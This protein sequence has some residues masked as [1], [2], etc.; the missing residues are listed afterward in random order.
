[1]KRE[2]MEIRVVR[3]ARRKRFSLTV[4][5]EG[6]RL[7]APAAATEPEI[8]HFLLLCDSWIRKNRERILALQEEQ[9]AVPK[10]TEAEVSE[11]KKRAK[12]VF[13]ERAAYYAP[14]IGVTYGRITVTT[15]KSKWGSCTG[16]GNL[17]FHALLLLAPPQVLDSVVVHELCHRVHM[18]HSDAFY[19]LVKKH[20]PE[21]DYWNGWLKKHG[22]E[23]M[24]RLPEK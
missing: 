11:L 20:F 13:A 22:N 14:R 4:D 24:W 2:G 10:L 21:Y 6:L 12:K 16:K 7:N 9:A 15:P 23:L 3:S 17:S 1:M 5:S 19:R 8:R 18:N